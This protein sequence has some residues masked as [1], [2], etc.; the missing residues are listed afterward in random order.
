MDKIFLYVVL[1][2]IVLLPLLLLVIKT[3]KKPVSPISSF[4]SNLLSEHVPF[5]RQLS[6][7][8]KDEFE[9]RMQLFLSQVKITGTNTEVED[10]D[11]VLIG[12]S[13]IVPVFNLP[14]WEY[15]NLHEILLYPDSFNHEFDQYG[16]GRD[17]L[18][19]VGNGALNNM[20]IL[21]KQEL[22]L[23]FSIETDKRN[24]AIHEFIHLIDVTDGAMDG[25]PSAILDE[26]YIEPWKDIMQKEIELIRQEQSDINPYGATNTTEFFAV[27][28]EYFFERPDLMKEHHP[29]MY[30]L[31][32]KIFHC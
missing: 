16:P 13:A 7:Q 9:S 17:V 12:A 4:Y 28:S 11:K 30:V 5:Y 23:A 1:F 19:M 32:E 18:G 24:T 3:K 6:K 2:A 31:M 25:V 26:E 8:K 20:M 22:R 14:D 21:S 15:I 29:E 10:L 27:V